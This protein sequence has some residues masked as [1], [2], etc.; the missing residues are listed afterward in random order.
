MCKQ[1]NHHDADGIANEAEG[2]TLMM[3]VVNDGNE[4]DDPHDAAFSVSH[5]PR[6]RRQDIHM[7]RH[8]RSWN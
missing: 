3:W 4:E 1:I 5:A 7:K 2:Y 6:C 8:R